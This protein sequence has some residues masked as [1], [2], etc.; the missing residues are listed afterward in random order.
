MADIPGLIEGAHHGAGIGH[1]FLG[2]V[3][4]CR[5]LLHLID[6][7]QPDPLAAWRTIRS[8]LEKYDAQYQVGLSAKPEILALTKADAMPADYAEELVKA[9]RDTMRSERGETASIHIVSAVAGQG[10]SGLLR[11]LMQMIDQGRADEARQQAE[12]AAD[13]HPAEA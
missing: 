6:G 7:T 3:E 11:Q 5:V 4:R 2:H 13:W 1:R 10:M 9:L 12:P 8:E